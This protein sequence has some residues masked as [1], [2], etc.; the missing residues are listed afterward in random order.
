MLTAFPHIAHEN[1]WLYCR[2]FDWERF[3]F[4]PRDV[5]YPQAVASSA[6]AAVAP[7]KQAC[8][9]DKILLVNEAVNALKHLAWVP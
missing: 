6:I 4:V 8:V 7:L 2:P 5:G 3:T 9:A 1:I